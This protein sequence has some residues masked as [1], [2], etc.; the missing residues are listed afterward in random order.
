[1]SCRAADI[2]ELVGGRV[3][4]DPDRRIEGVAL[5]DRAGPDDL[6][7][8]TSDDH[9][10]QVLDGLGGTVITR[11][12]TALPADRTAIVVA[13]PRLAFAQAARAIVPEN[14][15]GSGIH[16]SA[17][18]DPSAVFGEGVHL[19]A[20]VVV[21][22]N[23]QIG[24]HVIVESGG[25][26]GAGCMVGSR[27]RLHPRVVLYSGTQ[28][29]SGCHVHSGTIIGSPGFGVVPT[30][31]GNVPFPQL[32]RVV[33]GDDVQ[34]GANCTIDRGALG[35]TVIGSG[36]CIDNLVHVAHGVQIGR[37]CLI[38][39]QSGLAGQA[40]LGDRV[41]VAG[42]VGVDQGAHLETDVRVGSRSWVVPGQHIPSGT[43]LGVPAAPIGDARRRIAAHRRLPALVRRVRE[44]ERRLKETDG[45][46]PHSKDPETS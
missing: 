2:A 21:E 20:H 3:L 45:L 35:D 43:W 34:I 16:P 9:L 10:A 41:H 5:P 13:D 19:G 46:T 39:G 14:R 22:A 23:A 7:F 17:V 31:V 8:A 27:T 15:P 26:V 32:G 11:R 4:G 1:M 28:L 24:D 30:L 37:D 40:Q 6:V 29:G 44:L 42:Q 12:V 36:T 18:I 38:A 25:V 33:V